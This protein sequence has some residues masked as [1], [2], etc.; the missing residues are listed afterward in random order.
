MRIDDVLWSFVFESHSSPNFLV[1][2][3]FSRELWQA[4]LWLDCTCSVHASIHSHSSRLSKPFS[5]RDGSNPPWSMFSHGFLSALNEVVAHLVP[6]TFGSVGQ[7]GTKQQSSTPSGSFR[8]S[9]QKCTELHETECECEPRRMPETMFNK[10]K[11][12]LV[13]QRFDIH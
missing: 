5:N 4:I 3:W 13:K 9:I 6:T 1:L 8:R 10:A 7:L 11:H 2:R 12:S